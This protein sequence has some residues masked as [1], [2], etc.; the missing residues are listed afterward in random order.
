MNYAY[1]ATQ[2]TTAAAEQT[3]QAS[4]TT[5]ITTTPTTSVSI[6][7][8]DQ[9]TKGTVFDAVISL[10]DVLNVVC[11]LKAFLVIGLIS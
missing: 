3:T 7:T 9:T 1:T 4:T 5:T 6:T 11:I 10:Q 8:Q 2:A